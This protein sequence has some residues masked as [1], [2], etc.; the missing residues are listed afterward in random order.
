MFLQHECARGREEE[1]NMKQV[2]TGALMAVLVSDAAVAAEVY[3]WTTESEWRF[4]PNSASVITLDDVF[5]D[6]RLI[7]GN[8]AITLDRV[9]VG[10]RRA[11]SAPA[12][13]ITIWG[14]PILSN[15]TGPAAVGNP[16]ALGTVPLAARSNAGLITE[17]VSVTPGTTVP[18]NVLVSG[19]RPNFSGLFIGVSFSNTSTDNGWIVVSG[20]PSGANFTNRYFQF[21]T[22]TTTAFGPNR[23][24]PPIPSAFYSIIE[25][26]FV[27]TPGALALLGLGGIVAGRRRR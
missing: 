19:P 9:T 27:P 26:T 22:A 16:V 12:T 4:T 25:G 17:L 8:S 18:L 23:F 6:N 11:G 20:G 1:M 2:I 24:D 5:I 10:I 7:G 15:L 21:D 13:D 14:A 3:N